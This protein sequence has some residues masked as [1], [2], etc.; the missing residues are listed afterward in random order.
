[1]FLIK[2]WLS[3]NCKWPE[4][5]VLLPPAWSWLSNYRISKFCYFSY[6]VIISNSLKALLSLLWLSHP[7]ISKFYQ[8]FTMGFFWIGNPSY[9]FFLG[10][11][12]NYILP[13]ISIIIT[14][15][16]NITVL[17]SQNIF[18]GFFMAM[19]IRR[20]LQMPSTTSFSPTRFSPGLFIVWQEKLD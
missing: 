1:M 17:V 18:F 16:S 2:A 13:I 6:M 8:P 12:R 19:S 10:I 9:L 3:E 15:V 5:Q 4:T 14:I 11:G 7:P 20:L